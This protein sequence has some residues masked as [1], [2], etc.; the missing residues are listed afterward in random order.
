MQKGLRKKLVTIWRVFVVAL[1]K[2]LNMERRAKGNHVIIVNDSYYVRAKRG[3]VRTIKKKP[4]ESIVDHSG[5]YLEFISN[6]TYI[7]GNQLHFLR[8]HLILLRM[9]RG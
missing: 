5:F 6:L 7:S 2:R 4:E 9:H 3:C 8:L 1:W